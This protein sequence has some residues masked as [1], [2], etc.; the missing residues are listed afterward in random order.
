MKP[1]PFLLF[2]LTVTAAA[3]VPDFHKDVAPI[4][5]EYCAGCH[6]DDEL[7]GEFSV[8]TFKSL[9]AGGDSG[10]AIVPGNAA[11]S[12]LT[13]LI[14][15]QKKPFMPPRKEPQP[16]PVQ[17]EVLK[18]WIDG[19]APTPK[20]DRSILATLQVPTAKPAALR[21]QPITAMAVSRGGVRALGSFGRVTIGKRTFT[22]HAGKVNDLAFSADGN[23][24]LA[25]SGVTGLRGEA[26]LW[27]LKSGRRE[28]TFNEG[29]R[30]ILY[31]AAFSPDDRLVATAGYDQRIQLWDRQTGKHLRTLK[32]HNG[33]VHGIAFSPDGTV[34][35]SAGGDAAVKLWHVTSGQRLDTFGQPTG[36][37]FITAF[38]P[39]SRFVAAAGAD[40]QIRLWRWISKTKPAINPLAR[41]RYAH[42]D[43]I[44]DLTISPDGRR[45]A[46]AAADRTVKIWSLPGLQLLQQFPDQPDIVS[47]IG[48][49][50]SGNTLHLARLNGTTASHRIKP[51]DTETAIAQARA[52]RAIADAEA[53]DA[54]EQ[55]P[56][57]TPAQATALTLPAKVTGRI[58]GTDGADTDLY[59]FNARAGEQ[60]VLE[61]NAA[62]SKSPLD[63]KLEVLSADGAPIE[64]VRL[65]AMRDSWL[66]FRGKDS[67]TSGD[68]R[69]F[70]WDEM[71]LNQYLYVNGEVV[72]LW[73]YPRGPDSG[74]IVYP[75]TGNRHTFFDTTPL[76]HPLGQPA[77]IVEPR[78]P[79]TPS[80]ANGLP[81]FP[82]YFENDDESRR[83]WGKDS[84]L[85][86]TTPADGEYLVRVSDVRG[87]SGKDFSY[88]L[89]VR[90][91]RP[92]FTVSLG[93]ISGGGVPKGSGRE[94]SITAQ[95]LD[96][97]E[98]PI[99]VELTDA[100][101]GFNITTPIII[102][103]G[104]TR[105]FGGVYAATD[106]PEPPKGKQLAKVSASAEIGGQTITHLVNDLTNLKPLA[107]AKLK[108]TILTADGRAPEPGKL[109][110]L[111]IAPGQTIAALVRIERNGLKE[112]VS[113]GSHDSGR[114]LPYG[115]YVD[116]IGLNG[117]LIVEEA[118]E[119]EFYITADAVTGETTRRFHLKAAPEGGI[120]STPVLLKVRKK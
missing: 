45:L 112:R 68:F 54:Q 19:G 77:Y 61:I 15:G 71:N 99:R 84:Q 70:K 31:G 32:G 52:S 56:N 75:G 108:V 79:G 60:W 44:T 35:A 120:L 10:K 4:L 113:F 67:N 62:R 8:E 73:H 115:A 38:T 24:M 87:F 98:G 65:Q 107:P 85:T 28:L 58:Y 88:T 2:L 48:F 94:F 39:D 102:Q 6:N 97:Y 30:D 81:M 90:P 103:A 93:G 34:L 92:N 95:R 104:Q 55:E 100:P 86:F 50:R 1:L 7:D 3:A 23:F 117:L 64:R 43:E 40:K 36:E 105:A 21:R 118:S 47:A 5:R 22:G 96:G 17:I 25:A 29:H 119:R 27:N 106:A 116:N 13:H 89:T 20:V 83:R 18:A 69:L 101:E 110:E 76:A 46:S 109:L 59:R 37:Q 41:V 57:N 33:P 63:S 66:T 12:R 82:L 9:M 72:K 49:D 16:A 114:N 91:R 78:A 26:V 11:D 42:E 74:Y 53:T 51:L 111:E 80:A 14:T